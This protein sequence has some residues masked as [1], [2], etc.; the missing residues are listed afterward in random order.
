MA[1]DVIRGS[2]FV[3]VPT[4]DRQSATQAEVAIEDL[5]KRG[6]KAVKDGNTELFNLL[7]KK[8]DAELKKANKDVDV[9]VTYETS[10]ASGGFKE[11]KKAA[12]GA[13]KGM[14][15]DYNKMVNIQG[16]SALAVKKELAVHRDKINQLKQQSLIL[17][18]NSTSY[19]KNIE[20]QRGHTEEA[21]R[22]EGVLAK[23]STLSSLKGQLRD[24]SQRLSM[25]SQYNMELDKQGKMVAVVNKE[26][27]AQKG[28]VAGLSQ[29]VAAAGNAT[30]GFGAKIKG[31]G[32]SIQSA[33]G[34]VTAIIAGIT[35]L[36]GS[37][38]M[39]TGRVKDI[40]ALK[41][42]FDGLGQSVE[43]QNAIL[44][45]ARNIALSYGVSL[46]KVEGAFRRLGPAILES[47]GSLKDTEGAIKSISARTT[48]LGLNT[49]QAGRYIEAFA[50]VMGKGKLQSEELNQQ[51]SE[52]DGG[53]RGQLK[54]WLAA[55]KGI[56]DFEGAM[57]KG[58]ITSGLFLEAFEA[59]NEE[60][61]V[62]FLR[63]IGE[64]QKGIEE[65]GKK[66]GMTLNQLNAK[67]QTLTSIG[68]ESV[69]KAL[70]PLGKELM[71]I[72][73]AFVQVF[74]KVATEMPGVAALFKFLGHII[75]VV[76]KVALN[77]VLYLFG[78]LM[79]AIDQLVR[80]VMFL[81]DALKNIPGIGAMLDGLEEMAKK[82]NANFDSGIDGFSKLSDETI[83]ATAEL[84][85][86]TDE[87][88][89]LEDQYKKGEITQE[90]YAKK[91]EEILARQAEAVRRNAEKELAIEQDKM[92]KMIEA[93][94]AQLDRDKQLMDRKVEKINAAKD[95]EIAS[96]DQSIQ[97]LEGQKDAI[98]QVYD[99]KIEAVK[100]AAEAE[101]RAIQE[102]IDALNQQKT[103]VKDFYS[104][105]LENVKSY[106]SELKSQMDSAHSREMTQMDEKISALRARQSME[107]GNFSS[108][109]QN[110]KLDL[111]KI[112]QLKSRIAGETDRY[113]KQEM[114]AQI[115]NIQLSK[116]RALLEKQHADEMKKALEEKKRLEQKQ[117]EE[118]K[119]LDEEEKERVKQIQD[120]QQESLN[121]IKE[122]VQSLAEQK[123]EASRNEKDDVQS[124]Q[125]AKKAAQAE[126]EQMI[127]DEEA[128]R[129]AANEKAEA[130]IDKLVKAHEKERQKIEDIA[131]EMDKQVGI[132]GE[133][134]K[135][136]DAVTNGALER[137][138]QKVLT[139]K[140]EM[141]NMANKT[142]SN[143]S[144]V[145]A[146]FAGGPVSG[147]STYTVNEL[148]TE[149]FLSASGR[150]SEIKA[151]AFGDWKAPSSG[152]VIPAHVWK[153]I[154]A[155]QNTEINMP[156]SV[157][158]G[159]AV[160]R[161]ISTINNSTG[162]HVQNS[163]TIQA[164]NP[165]QAAS[166]IMVQ[167]AKIKRLRY[168]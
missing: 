116:Q 75:G 63:S 89:N 139:I 30:K 10:S 51:F 159:N 8:M 105:Q 146:R 6:A 151:P 21:K 13:L 14:I 121:A 125:D 161:A 41:L 137:Q 142:A 90:Q 77:T 85:K 87:L 111:M 95:A 88:A 143:T 45:S 68:L 73:A 60:I 50:Q 12:D 2:N 57:K 133:V 26:W 76:L 141:A 117:A 74:T 47:G 148:G 136:V 70:A 9:K 65:M 94:E 145:G 106:Y 138:L 167:L 69:G 5:V 29:Q 72:Y 165:T 122:A 49:E 108:G 55:N 103:A 16:Q 99:Q 33:F 23:V 144:T 39:L 113:K 147:G 153:G 104:N 67:L 98:D 81:Y 11:V 129:E 62:K 110:E 119:K 84:A 123:K 19:K 158:P 15:G 134:G 58:E 154:K 100:R 31:L 156:R 149:G 131:W 83:G 48:M 128:K 112:Q 152:S 28:V 132:Q 17:R 120:A 80:G 53:L 56:T 135:A 157:S 35:A 166:D 96:I 97:A 36:A 114:R 118:K 115:E 86:Y 3:I 44:G 109:P 18:K 42:T 64:T 1:G 46:R 59:I 164:I 32:Q 79:E 82:L 102:A 163:V 101:K 7:S 38:G 155:S 107:M 150:M 93:R 43:A 40:Q 25:M 34:A 66:G 54:N 22:L 24:E 126:V 61:R 124:L 52:L 37:I 168:N 130:A 127:E 20:L 91:R 162:D 4:V 78:A 140:R 27:V 92:N 71:K 160:A